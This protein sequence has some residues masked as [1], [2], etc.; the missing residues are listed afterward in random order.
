MKA[1]L[2]LEN[3]LGKI[4]FLNYAVSPRAQLPI[5]SGFLIRA[6]KGKIKIS[7]TDLETGIEV[8]VPASVDQEGAVAVPAK[9]FSEFVSSLSE[10]KITIEK[11]QTGV[12]VSGK[13]VSAR[14]NSLDEEEFPK[15]YEEK[16]EELVTL[17]EEALLK[18]L[19]RVV[20]AASPE[21]GR[22]AFSGVLFKK[23][24]PFLLMVAT[25]S[26]RLS[27]DKIKTQ[28]TKDTLNKG[29]VVSAK[30]LRALL[31]RKGGGET[32][33]YVSEKN[34]QIIFS[35]KDSTLVG[36]LIEADYPEFEKIIPQDLSTK[37]GFL[38]KDL[39]SA[40][41][42]ASVFAR[43][44][45]NIVKIAIKKNSLTVSAKSPTLGENSTQISASTTGEENEIAFNSHYLLELLQNTG[46]EEMFFEMTGPLNP[47][48]FKN[49]K[50]P[51]FI[52][53]IMPIRIR[54]EELPR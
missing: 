27:L 48:V 4:S 23:E 12:S 51:N 3:L 52:H 49:K 6:E 38:T 54:D 37:T 46:A 21:S 41:K 50:D 14:I 1:A 32:R 7:A 29:V 18:N 40:L 33:V 10:E 53:L 20:F 24:G 17:T 28:T 5:L 11:T 2:L 43:E 9:T 44:N 22:P 45:A 35:Q 39:L 8:E 16:G 19:P 30:T 15:I 26:H 34:N 47:G 36:R 31:S 25:D 13:N 42:T